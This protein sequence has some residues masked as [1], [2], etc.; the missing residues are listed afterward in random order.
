MTNA[1]LCAVAC[2]AWNV[3]LFVVPFWNIT[4]NGLGVFYRKVL[5]LD[6]QVMVLMLLAL[7][8]SVIGSVLIGIFS[9]R[10][11]DVEPLTRQGSRM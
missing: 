1:L 7:W 9:V 10:D 6:P 5:A 4:G 11:E 8:M 3:L 2:L